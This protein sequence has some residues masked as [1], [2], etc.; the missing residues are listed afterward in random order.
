MGV[1]EGDSGVL[2]FGRRHTRAG[3]HWGDTGKTTEQIANVGTKDQLVLGEGV[4]NARA[5]CR[6]KA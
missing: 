1:V 3:R 4:K 5:M 2:V 6:A